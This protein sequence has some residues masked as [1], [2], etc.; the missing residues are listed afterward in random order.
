MND[1]YKIKIGGKYVNWASVVAS[2][3]LFIGLELWR[4]KYIKR[5]IKEDVKKEISQI[6]LPDNKPIDKR[7]LINEILDRI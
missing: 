6:E 4:R 2:G 3:I 7:Q 1:W 5:K